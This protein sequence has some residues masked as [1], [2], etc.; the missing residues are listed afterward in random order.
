MQDLTAELN[1]SSL[2]VKTWSLN[3]WAT[4][5]VPLSTH[6]PC[7]KNT[8]VQHTQ[9][10]NSLLPS[11]LPISIDEGPLYNYGGIFHSA[12]NSTFSHLP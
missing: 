7:R 11:L 9:P 5:E 3:C 12:S 10:E 4:G 1:P 6:K 2:A 8:P